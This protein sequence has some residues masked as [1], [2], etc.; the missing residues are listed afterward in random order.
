MFNLK[1]DKKNHKINDG[2]GL[3]NAFNSSR[4]VSNKL[5]FRFNSSTVL[6]IT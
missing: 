6:E 2:W 5:I 3:T 4:S 1:H